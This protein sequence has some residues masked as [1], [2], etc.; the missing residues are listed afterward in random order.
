MNTE[1]SA[2]HDMDKQLGWHATIC[3]LGRPIRRRHGGELA[4]L[5]EYF[6][7]NRRTVAGEVTSAG[8]LEEY[9]NDA[10]WGGERTAAIEG[11]CAD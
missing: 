6:I 8:Q 3:Y 9:G 1:P 11:V 4:A 10:V 7:S 2:F 5:L